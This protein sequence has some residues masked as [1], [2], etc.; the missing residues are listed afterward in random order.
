MNRPS[1]NDANKAKAKADP[2]WLQ[3][4]NLTVPLEVELNHSH[5]AHAIVVESD[6]R[7]RLALE[8]ADNG[9]WDLDVQ[10]GKCYFSPNSFEMFG[11]EFT[12]R[13]TYLDDW[14]NLI[15]LDDLESVRST[16]R[17]CIDGTVQKFQ[18]EFRVRSRE[19]K[20][21]W[22]LCKGKSVYRDACGRALRIVGTVED[23]SQAKMI[24][25]MLRMEHD[26]LDLITSTSPVG[27]IF[28]GGDGQVAFANPRAEQI[29]GQPRQE[30]MRCGYQS[31]VWL[32]TTH[33]GLSAEAELP[34]REVLESG[35]TLNNTDFAVRRPDGQLALLSIHAAPFL[36]SAG[37][38]AGRVV[39]LEDVTERKQH[40][41]VLA[42]SDRLLRETQR[43]AQLGSYVLTLTDDKWTCSGRL[44]EILGI[45]ASYPLNLRGH[46]DIVHPDYRQQF[47]TS[48]LSS[49]TRS[50]Q[51]EMEY[52]VRRFND[53]EPRWV[54]ECCEVSRDAAG[55]PARMIG[56]IQDITE[57]KAA[58]EAIR[59]LNEELDRR[60][61]ERTSQLAAAKK[62]IES[63][64]YSVSH[65]LRAPLR[66][67][68]SYSAILLEDHSSFLSFEARD[69][70]NRI[71]SASSRMGN[72]IDDL[73]TLTRVGRT[74]MKR[75]V[76]DISNIAEQVAQML[77]EAEPR[78]RAKFVIQEG[79]T[80]YG[81]S[82]LVRL[83]LE[84]LLGNSMKYTGRQH[85][86]EIE[87][88][89]LNEE[90]IAVFFVRDDGVGFDMAYA[91]NMFRPFQRLHGAEF[92]GT[93]IG[94][95]TVKRI[96]ERHGGS[97]WA[98]GKENEGATFYFRLS[99]TS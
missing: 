94:L 53:G 69:Y 4:G 65:D 91:D 17:E 2:I 37:A 14:F 93:G 24:Q 38:V 23:V 74:N 89:Q 57:R 33:S 12:E 84:N 35:H 54:A 60:V 20:W 46:F 18:V 80:A 73:L 72:L 10:T 86:A 79:L 27:I 66:H 81:D 78:S 42:D 32:I 62:E 64:S 40:E 99:G 77:R 15:H 5:L 7:Y 44:L 56:T 3:G 95:A 28:I 98:E 63:F 71:C 92:E 29:L 1:V 76:F 96:I 90:G 31:P 97:V 49:I 82:I 16:K 47:M 68:N 30:I 36:D 61:I 51:F 67:I 59:N 75:E 34:L 48:Y 13:R 39:I 26:L 45:D 22:L 43:I 25:Q 11:I 6:D 88:G 85:E 19:G 70:L 55:S 8:A 21:R 87:F 50:G 83:V 58:E 9:I 41:Q 52:L